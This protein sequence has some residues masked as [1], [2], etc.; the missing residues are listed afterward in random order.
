MIFIAKAR[1]SEIAKIGDVGFLEISK[2]VALSRFRPFALLRSSLLSGL[3]RVPRFGVRINKGETG[4]RRVSTLLRFRWSNGSDISPPFHES[5]PI[6]SRGPN[7]VIFLFFARIGS[8][9]FAA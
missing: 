1:K 8:E 9:V 6:R 2:L 5:K 3:L 4:S 7:P